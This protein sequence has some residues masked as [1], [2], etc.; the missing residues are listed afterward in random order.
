MP[1]LGTTNPKRLN[2]QA[3]IITMKKILLLLALFFSEKIYSQIRDIHDPAI[4]FTTEE[5]NAFF[6][7]TDPIYNFS[8]ALLRFKDGKNGII[9]RVKSK[10]TRIT[11]NVRLD[12][13]SLQFSDDKILLLSHPYRDTLFTQ[14]NEL[15]QTIIYTI[16]ENETLLLKTKTLSKVI[17]PVDKTP[18]I[19]EF[20][21]NNLIELTNRIKA[22]L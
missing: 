6:N 3:L 21:R 13:I 14:R 8:V 18:F 9:F 5:V 19:I 20:S 10:N 15:S 2:S 4:F 17:F 22:T 11:H 1:P 7:N 16:D 12:S